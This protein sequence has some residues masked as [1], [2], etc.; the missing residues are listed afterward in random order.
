MGIAFGSA[1]NRRT[2]LKA[3]LVAGGAVVVR[4]LVAGAQPPA[5]DTHAT[6]SSSEWRRTAVTAA[7]RID[8]RPKVTGAKVYAAD[9]RA[10][11]MPGWPPDTAHAML[12][13]APDATHI[14]EGIDFAGLDAEPTPDRVV[15]AHD[16]VESAITVPEFYAGDLL[17]LPGR[18]RSI[19]G[20]R[21]RS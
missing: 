8:G 13:K 10:V 9:F 20:S 18:P 15:L 7:R 12:L 2:L 11:D 3:S 5:F 6:A 21:S 19:S 17:A 1:I 14:F 16:I 4:P